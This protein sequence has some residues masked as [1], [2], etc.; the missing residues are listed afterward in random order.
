MASHSTKLDIGYLFLGEGE[1]NLQR[2]RHACE[3]RRDC[4][5]H[6]HLGRQRKTPNAI[7]NPGALKLPET[8]AQIFLVA[9]AAESSWAAPR[10]QT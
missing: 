7:W 6:T 3:T 2:S 8:A 9:A 4:T 5:L 1:L 10:E